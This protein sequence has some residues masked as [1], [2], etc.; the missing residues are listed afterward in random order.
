MRWNI[1]SCQKVVCRIYIILFSGGYR[2]R[3]ILSLFLSLS[4]QDI[5]F[6]TVR[7]RFRGKFLSLSRITITNLA[8]P[9]PTGYRHLRGLTVKQRARTS[10]IRP[11]EYLSSIFASCFSAKGINGVTKIDA[12]LKNSMKQIQECISK[13][14][15]VVAVNKIIIRYSNTRPSKNK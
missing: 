15:R 11:Q 12:E 3:D 1:F 6:R 7:L 9:R 5:I 14:R 2:T 10:P 4:I 8:Q 13:K